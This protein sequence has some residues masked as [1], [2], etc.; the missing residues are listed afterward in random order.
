MVRYIS[1][2]STVIIFPVYLGACV[3]ACVRTVFTTASRF[4]NDDDDECIHSIHISCV[5]KNKN[6]HMHKNAIGHWANFLFSLLC[7]VCVLSVYMRVS[8]GVRV[9]VYWPI[10]NP[11][12]HRPEPMPMECVSWALFLELQLNHKTKKKNKGEKLINY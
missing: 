11:L 5:F 6:K 3:C 7:L 10:D 9:C 2:Q 4:G 8:H 12:E 1:I